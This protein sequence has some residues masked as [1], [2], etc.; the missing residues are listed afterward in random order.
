MDNLNNTNTNKIPLRV[1]E[2]G[3]SNEITINY[4]KKEDNIFYKTC[5]ND[6]CLVIAPNI[7]CI[8]TFLLIIFII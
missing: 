8:G 1:N 3:Y 2:N 4:K 5:I 7:I 6:L